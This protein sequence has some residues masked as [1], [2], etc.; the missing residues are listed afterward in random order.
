M[1][2]SDYP[3]FCSTRSKLRE[4]VYLTFR[5]VGDADTVLQL[6]I[7]VGKDTFKENNFLKSVQPGTICLQLTVNNLVHI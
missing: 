3:I 5:A 1:E 6:L 4:T 7:V 2:I